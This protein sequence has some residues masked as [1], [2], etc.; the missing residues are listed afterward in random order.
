M[1][2]VIFHKKSLKTERMSCGRLIFTLIELLVVIAIIGI[3]AAMLLPAF[4]NAKDA[5]YKISCKNSLKQ[6]NT[7]F[8]M[9]FDDYTGYI[10]PIKIG[11]VFDPTTFTP[12][13]YW[14]GKLNEYVNKEK[15]FTE[16]KEKLGRTSTFYYTDIAYGA[17]SEIIVSP[18]NID[19]LGIYHKVSEINCPDSKILFGDSMDIIQ[20]INYRGSE[21][22]CIQNPALPGGYPD[23]RHTRSANFA[24]AD[25]HVDDRKETLKVV[26]GE[27]VL[28][29]WANWYFYEWDQY[30]N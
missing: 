4:K 16:C 9:Y 7:A 20:N 8:N 26:A 27:V 14:F 1:V 10:V 11:S 19:S 6:I 24:Y 5:A 28:T 15:V 21:I 30:L 2:T 25:S 22:R 12:P 3:L 17:N 13:Y 18:D 23:F 29:Y